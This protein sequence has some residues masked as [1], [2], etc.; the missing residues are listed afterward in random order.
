[1]SNRVYNGGSEFHCDYL[2]MGRTDLVNQAV[3]QFGQTKVLNK[4]LIFFQNH[5]FMSLFQ[6]YKMCFLF[7]SISSQTQ[8]EVEKL[9]N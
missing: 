1:M 8:E 4:V 6:N 2:N 7:T 5:V 9:E 3:L